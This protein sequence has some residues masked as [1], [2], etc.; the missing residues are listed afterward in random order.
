MVWLYEH[1]QFSP[2]ELAFE[3]ELGPGVI[4]LHVI[5][6][7]SIHVWVPQST[8]SRWL[9]NGLVVCLYELGQS[10]SPSRDHIAWDEVYPSPVLWAMTL[11]GVRFGTN[12]DL[13]T[14]QIWYATFVVVVFIC[15]YVPGFVWSWGPLGWSVLSEI[16]LL[17]VLTG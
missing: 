10:S 4:P 15:I 16:F 11:L 8:I 3:V 7:R 1:E 13:G 9:K 12:G 6:A 17:E 2:F 5:R 14:L